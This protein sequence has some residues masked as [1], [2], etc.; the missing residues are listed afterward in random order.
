MEA[1]Y[2]YPDDFPLSR[3]SLHA[4]HPMASLFRNRFSRP[5]APRRRRPRASAPAMP[6][7]RLEERLALAGD[8][9]SRPILE[10]AATVSLGA[11]NVGPAP[12][13]FEH[14]TDATTGSGMLVVSTVAH[15]YVQKWDAGS[16]SWRDISTKPS[17]SDPRQLLQF[18]SQRVFVA[19]DR[20]QWVPA[21]G[22]EAAQVF[23][24][25]SQGTDTPPVVSP[26]A[27]L[28]AAVSSISVSASTAPD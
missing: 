17:S 25:V 2:A 4:W 22:A 3:F 18:L 8:T 26:D 10:R 14:V 28:P 12:I 11:T 15:G 24:I 13:V 21:G 1:V 23:D 27:P 19:G 16:S 9:I 6:F 5:V 20:L 7:E